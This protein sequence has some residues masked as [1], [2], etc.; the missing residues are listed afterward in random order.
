MLIFFIQSYSLSIFKAVLLLCNAAKSSSL[1]IN[2]E[3]ALSIQLMI[4]LAHGMAYA[5]FI[6]R[7]NIRYASTYHICRWPH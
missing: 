3:G 1:R 4:P 6:V 5:E 2:H 7:S